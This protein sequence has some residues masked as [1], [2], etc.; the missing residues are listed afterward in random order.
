[1]I[2]LTIPIN[3]QEDYFE[4]IDFN[5][6]EE[7]YGKLKFDLFGGGRSP[8]SLPHVSK[9]RL[10]GS[11]RTLHARNVRF[12]YL[13]NATCLDN[14]EITATGFRAIRKFL[15]WL[16]S[17]GV[18]SL[19]VSLPFL[20]QVIKKHYPGLK[21]TVSTQV[22]VDCLER[23]KYWEE[24][25]ADSIVLSY[26]DL[27]RNARELARIV[28][29]CSCG[30]QLIANLICRTRCPFVGLHGN[31]NAHASQAGHRCGGFALDYYSLFCMARMFSDPR[32]V[33]RSCWIRPEDL[34][35]YE[36]IGIQKIKLV[37]RGM[38]TEALSA[39]VSAYTARS[40]SGNFM[41]LI[42]TMSKYLYF[43]QGDLSRKL[44]PLFHPRKLNVSKL[45]GVYKI[46]EGLR[47]NADY[48]KNF[49][50]YID[51]RKLDGVV[52]HLIATDCSGTSCDACNYCAGV[53]KEAIAVLGDQATH[54][55]NVSS[56]S[57][58]LDRLV[59]GYYFQ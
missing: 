33:M 3:W 34:V 37:E 50:L 38:T 29:H 5:N 45:W 10:R 44:K 1:M 53:S 43:S 6:V 35:L 18:D 15:D 42:P 16:V 28:K 9:F 47:E 36:K 49:G 57:L 20:L 27:N 51:N 22:R 24:L 41:D 13:I 2:R 12:N 56:L 59:A 23:A 40:Y 52:E 8:L 54:L 19:T 7:V 14:Q 26:V 21:V 4:R 11:I 32:E 39:I 17:M 58:L 46:F 30:L 25:G 55:K 48:Y 31:F